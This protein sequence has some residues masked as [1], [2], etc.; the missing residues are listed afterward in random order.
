MVCFLLFW[1]SL[2]IF[3]RLSF[4]VKE[5]LSLHAGLRL[6]EL[7]RGIWLPEVELM[8][9]FGAE[10]LLRQLFSLLGESLCAELLVS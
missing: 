2:I 10:A 8:A 1:L 3:S 4:A 5:D 9:I 6:L 7:V